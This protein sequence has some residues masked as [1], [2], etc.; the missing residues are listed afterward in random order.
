MKLLA[1]VAYVFHSFLR[2]AHERRTSCALVLQQWK[3]GGEV[4]GTSYSLSE[5][6]VKSREADSPGRREKSL[7]TT[8]IMP[9]A[10]RPPPQLSPPFVHS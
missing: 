6:T 9:A 5:V 10:A 2:H 8:C 1:D 3:L 4:T 7:P